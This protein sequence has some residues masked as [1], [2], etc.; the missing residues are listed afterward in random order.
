MTRRPVLGAA[1]ILAAA[2]LWG[3][4]GLFGKFLYR[5][6]YTPLQ[7]AGVRA[8]IAFIGLGLV[9]LPQLHKLRIRAR[10]L[11][12]LVGYGIGGFA[13]FEA[14]YFL[15]IER[16]AV[17]VAA[18]LL[19]TAPAF[20]LLISSINERRK[21]GRAE[22][23]TLI[24]VL[25][26]VFLVTGVLHTLEEERVSTV[27]LL[28][29]LASGLSYGLFT[30][31]SKYSTRRFSSVTTAFYGLATAAIVMSVI[32]PAW[33]VPIHSA[34]TVVLLIALGIVATLVPFLLFLGG[35]A[36]LRAS[37]A[38]MLAS[39][40]PVVAT[41]LGVALLGESLAMD[42]VAGIA[43]IVSSALFLASRGKRAQTPT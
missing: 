28:L 20:V 12:F 36:Y 6:G 26:G 29:G 31:L 17:A 3:T 11:P 30:L 1:M 39:I 19:Y 35:L 34:R 4:L 5:D 43:L 8:T 2:S 32:A 18:A 41:L 13:F 10:D 7:L 37:T 21:P 38:S 27:G 24:A 22:I 16:T 42:Q 9:M 40:E 23:L 14:L 25:A 15:T 33:V